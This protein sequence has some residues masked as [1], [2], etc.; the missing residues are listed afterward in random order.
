MFLFHIM[1]YPREF[2]YASIITSP[3]KPQTKK[4]TA[5]TQNGKGAW[6]RSSQAKA[7]SSSLLEVSDDAPPADYPPAP[8]ADATPD[9]SS[10]GNSDLPY[11]AVLA[12]KM[13][14]QPGGLWNS[15]L[16]LFDD[17]PPADYPQPASAGDST[18]GAS[19]GLPYGAVLAPEQ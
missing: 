1:A 18:T 7:S 14:E 10:S 2:P 9:T 17:A 13:K 16:Q 4:K 11:G 15:F 8:T 19:S 12:A 5:W 6:Q 3:K